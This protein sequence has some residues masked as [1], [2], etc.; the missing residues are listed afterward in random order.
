MEIKDKSI[1]EKFNFFIRNASEKICD[2]F[3]KIIFSVKQ[4]FEKSTAKTKEFFVKLNSQRK[5]YLQNLAKRK[6]ERN[7]ARQ[8]KKEE[9]LKAKK[10]REQKKQEEAAFRKMR[11][12]TISARIIN[13]LMNIIDVFSEIVFFSGLIFCLKP[14]L[15]DF[16]KNKT[17]FRHFNFD[18]INIIFFEKILPQNL[19]I[20]KLTIF[21]I[22]CIFA[23]FLLYKII[24]SVAT[25]TGVNKI[26]SVLLSFTTLISIPLIKDKFLIF[27]V[28]YLLLF[29]S[30]QF[31]CGLNFKIISI[32]LSCNLV[33]IVAAYIF[34]LCIFDPI[35]KGIAVNLISELKLPLKW[36]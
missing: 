29:F 22:S 35:F 17:L 36:L 27:T 2:F 16:E 1:L 4:A 23:I 20:P 8:I 31:S 11:S 19:Q 12:K 18:S 28:L 32:K 33:L 5:K 14:E 25:A 21:I 6:S 9:N 30:F 24:F 10:E 34:I 15:L 3:H 7:L 26:I 13:V